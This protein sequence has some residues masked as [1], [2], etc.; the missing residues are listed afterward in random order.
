MTSRRTVCGGSETVTVEP[1][2][3]RMKTTTEGRALMSRAVSLPRN[4]VLPGCA[5]GAL[6]PSHRSALLLKRHL[7]VT[8]TTYQQLLPQVGRYRLVPGGQIGQRLRWFTA[9]PFAH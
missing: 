9:Q 1:S 7:F 8:V 4:S 2:G 6:V 3:L 5:F